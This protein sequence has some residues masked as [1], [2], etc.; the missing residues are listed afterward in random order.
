MGYEEISRTKTKNSIAFNKEEFEEIDINELFLDV[1]EMFEKINSIK[2][3]GKNMKL[4]KNY[5]QNNKK[6][7]EIK[8]LDNKYF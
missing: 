1:D 5:V 6:I 3:R 4:F 8:N 7:L 2:I